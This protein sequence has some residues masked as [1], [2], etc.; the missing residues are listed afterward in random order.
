M[1][2]K[3]VVRG[4]LVLGLL[5]IVLAGAFG[6]GREDRPDQEAAGDPK[7]GESAGL[8]A[9][10]DSLAN[11]AASRVSEGSRQVTSREAAVLPDRF[12]IYPGAVPNAAV[13]RNDD[14]RW[15]T[16]APLPEVGDYYE[17]ELRKEP[18]SVFQNMRA[19]T[20]AQVVVFS[21]FGERA[22]VGRVTFKPGPEGKGTTILLHLE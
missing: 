20:K 9:Q 14:F 13:P 3:R 8:V 17:A 19:S 21:R 4:N 18:W 16:S 2:A 6:C 11:L 12:P 15:D 5:V 7:A 1:K 22:P 10:A